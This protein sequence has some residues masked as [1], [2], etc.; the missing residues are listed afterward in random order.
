MATKKDLVEAQ[1]FAKRR[2][3]TAFVA[4]ADGK[5]VPGIA[6]AAK[7][8]GRYVADLVKVRLGGKPAPP[9]FAYRNAG[10]LATIGKRAAIVD[11]GWIKLRGRLAWWIWGIAHIF[12]L[13]GFRNRMIVLMDWASAYWT[14]RRHARV[15]HD[16]E[17]PRPPAG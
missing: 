6:P 5:P 4:G 15:V 2:L 17:A 12:F 16:V 13:I 3:T 8:Q 7:Q 14:F 10:N 11:F 1:S 9:P